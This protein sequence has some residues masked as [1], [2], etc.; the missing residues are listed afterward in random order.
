MQKTEKDFDK[1]N[2]KKKHIEHYPSLQRPQS[3]EL[4]W[5]HEW[6]NIGNE[7]S[8]GMEGQFRRIGM[9]LSTKNCNGIV[10][11]LPLT[12]KYQE[13]NKWFQT[14]VHNPEKYRLREWSAII[15]NQIRAISVKR[16]IW[17]H[18]N[19]SISKSLVELIRKKCL[20]FIQ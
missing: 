18:S 19:I 14:L 20:Q 16:L 13:K 6:I 7:Q 10:Y 5:Y 15:T 3:G 11:I 8:K 12:T 1:W 17:V 9:I 4:R 2:D